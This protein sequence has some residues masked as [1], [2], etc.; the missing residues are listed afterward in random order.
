[1]IKML[2]INEIFTL[3]SSGQR[4]YVE[5]FER[6]NED[7]VDFINKEIM[8]AAKTGHRKLTIRFDKYLDNN[9]TIEKIRDY[10]K[11]NDLKTEITFVEMKP[12]YG[13]VTGEQMA[14]EPIYDAICVSW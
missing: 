2:T 10:L 7:I 9:L 13:R 3:T 11:F 8:K 12:V 14:S 4:E 6:E 1:M 5:K